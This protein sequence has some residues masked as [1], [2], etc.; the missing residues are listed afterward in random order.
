MGRINK[1]YEL[2]GFLKMENREKG[3]IKFYR[4]E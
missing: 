3:I 2:Q 1:N 4:F